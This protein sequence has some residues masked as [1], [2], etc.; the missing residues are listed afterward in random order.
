ISKMVTVDTTKGTKYLSVKALI[1]NNV[2]GMDSR[3]RNMELAKVDRQIVFKN[4]CASCH[5]EPAKGKH[6]EALYAAAC[7]IC[8]DSPHRATMVPD[9][10]A[11]KTNPTP[12]YWKAWVSN[13]KPGSLM[14]A[15]A[16]SQNGILDDDQ[17]ASLVEY[18]SKNF[19]AK[20]TPETTAAGAAATGAR[21]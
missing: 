8:H 18:L 3:T 7:A 16:K 19:P 13:G 20:Q 4:D 5:A 21:P 11:L 6:G 15:F 14:P 17:I 2:A 1:P 9:L 12:E 10:R